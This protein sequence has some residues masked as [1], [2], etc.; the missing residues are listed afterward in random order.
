[1]ITEKRIET[2][3]EYARKQYKQIHPKWVYFLLLDL[4]EKYKTLK[5][6]KSRI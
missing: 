5:K 2:S 6:E 3:I 1:M 4:W